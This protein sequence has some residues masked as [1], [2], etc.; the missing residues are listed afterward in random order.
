MAERVCR[1]LLGPEINVYGTRSRD[2]PGESLGGAGRASDV[3]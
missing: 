2:V 1:P 3:P